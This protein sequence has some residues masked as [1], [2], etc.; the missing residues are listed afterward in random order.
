MTVMAQLK[1]G[2]SLGHTGRKLLLIVT[3]LGVLLVAGA[4]LGWTL[5]SYPTGWLSAQ[6]EMTA[7]ELFSESGV[8]IE[9]VGYYSVVQGLK[10][11][12]YR[13]NTWWRGVRW[14]HPSTWKWEPK[15]KTSE[16][17]H[18]E[19]KPGAY[20]LAPKVELRMYDVVIWTRR[21]EPEQRL[22]KGC[23]RTDISYLFFINFADFPESAPARMLVW[24]GT[25]SKVPEYET[26]L[27][28]QVGTGSDYK[29]VVV[30]IKPR[31]PE[32]WFREAAAIA[33]KEGNWDP[34][35][36]IWR[37]DFELDFVAPPPPFHQ[38]HIRCHRDDS[39]VVEVRES[40]SLR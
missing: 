21:G 7:T 39:G 11:F 20:S 17:V 5:T 12:G 30:R 29:V 38:L 4:R 16:Y 10:P 14:N 6:R 26:L 35:G 19:I 15:P 32:A 3:L 40:L 36:P 31:D 1:R 28:G 13:V 25:A 34:Q 18:F 22:P 9:N 33:I 23:A 24:R 2:G 27:G 8:N 37:S